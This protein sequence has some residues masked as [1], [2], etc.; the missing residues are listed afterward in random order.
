MTTSEMSPSIRGAVS[1]IKQRRI[2]G[3]IVVCVISIMGCLLVRKVV[4][5]RLMVTYRLQYYPL[6][7]FLY[8]F[9]ES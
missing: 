4:D 5:I 2:N 7:V 1:Y 8:Y 6:G 3:S 9:P